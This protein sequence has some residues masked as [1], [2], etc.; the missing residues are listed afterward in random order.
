MTPPTPLVHVPS[1]SVTSTVVKSEPGPA[2]Q[3][4]ELCS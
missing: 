1:S 3:V 4:S 2:S